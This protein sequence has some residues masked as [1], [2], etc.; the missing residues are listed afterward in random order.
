MLPDRDDAPGAPA[1]IVLSHGFWERHFG[2]DGSVIGRTLASTVSP[3]PSSAWRRA[4]SAASASPRPRLWA[5]VT[6]QPY[7][8]AGSSLLT[9]Y[10]VESSGVQMYGRLAP[11]MNPRAAEQELGLLAAQLR[12]QNPAGIWEKEALPS[13]PAGY[14]NTLR[15][16]NG[17]GTGSEGGDKIYPV[18]ALV[19]VLAL[20]I[21]AVACAN[22]GS[23]L[24]ARG[25]AR[26]REISIRLAVGAG[27]SRLVRQLF[28][29]SLVLALLGSAAGLW[30]G[31]AVL[32]GLMSLTGAP[33]WMDPSP[34]R[35]IAAFAVG[36]GFAAAILFGLVPALQIARQKH[37]ATITRQFL[38]GAQVA[39]SCVLLIVAGLLGRA[40]N[41]AVS[42]P[43]GFEYQQV[44]SID[45]GLL[46][47]GYSPAKARV[48]LDE[49]RARLQALPG[50]QSVSLASCPPL[51]HVSVSAGI[52]VDG[53][54]FSIQ[55]NR[56]DPQFLSTMKIPLMRG[57]NLAAGETH[58]VVIGE[59]LARGMWPGQD[60]L[61]KKFD[62]NGGYTVVGVAGSARTVKP[63]DSDSVEAY[64]PIETADLPVMFV[65]AR[66]AGSPE[67]LARNA[68]IT[69][70]ELDSSAYPEVQLLKTA[71]GRKLENA[72]TTA[73]AVT[74]MGLVA[75]LLACLGILGVVAYA[76]SQRTREIGIRMALGAK[77]AH[78]L[79]VVLRHLLIPVTVGLAAGIAGAAALSNVLRQELFG[80][81]HLDPAA[82][83]GA[84]AVFTVTVTAAAVLPAR[85]ALRVDPWRALRHE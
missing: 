9:D 54:S 8:S 55:L 77:P 4:S 11:G 44:V 27:S 24:L 2:G 64:L 48:F 40:L 79:G 17:R 80:I 43:P 20:L 68:S 84:L 41:H 70:H 45:P 35:R 61:G 51:G 50:V 5:P 6:T 75:Q 69:A 46:R 83:G 82:Y 85:R 26:Q 37:R 10:S 67:D 57:R 81:S 47:H 62:L 71:Y 38:V 34:D 12:K 18:F 31:S 23:L 74:A 52:E 65:L 66:T 15:M 39:A 3:P 28:T 58:S 36:M 53:R 60:P 13:D 1:V 32:R 42:A 25:V 49:L 72:Q 14:A 59:S 19:G 73:M 63:E 56:V 33:P 21:L 7:F 16:G 30:L 76:V 78:V 22:L 29:E